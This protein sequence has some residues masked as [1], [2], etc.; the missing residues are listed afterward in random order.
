MNKSIDDIDF[1]ND[2][3]EIKNLYAN[4]KYAKI[5]NALKKKLVTLKLEYK[6]PT[7]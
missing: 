1:E 2:P 4:P 7:R 3:E 5:Q 6:V